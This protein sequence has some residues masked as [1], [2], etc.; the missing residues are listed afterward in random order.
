MKNLIVVLSIIF[1]SFISQSCSKN[2][3][4]CYVFTQTRSTTVTDSR[5]PFAQGN[6]QTTTSSSVT[7]DITEKEADSIAKQL[8]VNTTSVSGFITTK[9]KT[10]VSVRKK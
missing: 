1:V 5:N 3:N 2:G 10:T 8:E 6:P 9:V 7:C 4:D